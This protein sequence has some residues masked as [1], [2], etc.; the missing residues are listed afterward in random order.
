M[1][2]HIGNIDIPE[3]YNII[4]L[5]QSDRFKDIYKSKETESKESFAEF[6]KGYSN[7]ILDSFINDTDN[8]ALDHYIYVERDVNTGSIAEYE[9]LNERYT[10]LSTQRDDL[11]KAVTNLLGVIEE[12]DELMKV[13]FIETFE[14]ISEEFKVSKFNIFI[15]IYQI[16]I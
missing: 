2:T 4:D 5:V 13:R 3:I 1:L 16:L 7:D 14:K 15:F 9:R 12:M 11:E 8:V 10:F 6:L